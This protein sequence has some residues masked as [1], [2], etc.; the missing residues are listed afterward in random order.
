MTGAADLGDLLGRAGSVAFV[1]AHPD[2]ET[3]ATG[4][5]IGHLV[6]AGVTVAVLTATRGERGEV[7]PPAP[8]GVVDAASLARH[9]EGELAGALTE[10]GV[11]RHA[12]LGTPPARAAGLR[13]RT[14]RDSGMRWLTSTRAGPA[15]DVDDRSFTSASVAEAVADTAAVLGI[16]QPGLVIGYD[17]IGGYGHPD[18]VRA[19]EVAIGAARHLGVP[20]AEVL[21]EPAHGGLWFDLPDQLSRV[22]AALRHHRTQ[23]R[24]DGA[25]VRHSGGQVE[26]IVTAVG[27][28]RVGSDGGGGQPSRPGFVGSHDLPHPDDQ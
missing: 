17:D 1:H 15:A 10:L 18:H 5:L 2:D 11:T 3:L 25:S 28:R 21:T 22:Q 6:D 14:Y 24:V 9:R 26:P 13:P 16:W 20:F 7:V 8:V 4:A 27:L 19:R 23:L 12:F